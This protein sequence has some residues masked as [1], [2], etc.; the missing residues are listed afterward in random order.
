MH[1]YVIERDLPGAGELTA[2]ELHTIATKSNAVIAEMNSTKPRVQWV[3]SY[4][5][6]D[7]IYCIYRA[8]DAESLRDHAGSGGFPANVVSEVTSFFDPTTGD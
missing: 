8:V 6:A 2:A 7:K 4:V 1:T 3:Q 5:T